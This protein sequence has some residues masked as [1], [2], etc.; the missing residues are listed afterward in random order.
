MQPV[1][2][3][4]PCQFLS[5]VLKALFFYQSSL[6]IRL[7]LQKLQNFRRIRLGALPP[8]PRASG[9]WGLCPQTPGA[10]DPLGLR[11]LGASPQIFK[12]SPPLRISGYAPGGKQGTLPP[13]KILEV[14]NDSLEDMPWRFLS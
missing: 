4:L 13:S 2:S 5:H 3:G 7:F 12:H 10:P 11:R 8:D 1:Y 14:N 9:G 6:K